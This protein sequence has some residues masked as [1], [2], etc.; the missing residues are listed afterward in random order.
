MH[1]GQPELGVLQS[2]VIVMFRLLLE[3]DTPSE[4]NFGMTFASAAT[5]VTTSSTTG[6]LKSSERKNSVIIALNLLQTVLINDYNHL[7]ILKHVCNVFLT[8][9]P[10]QV[11]LADT[12]IFNLTLFFN[13]FVR[14]I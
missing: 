6:N 4:D 14:T 7:K 8:I 13:L 3:R 9:V 2:G 1:Q 5:D 10:T 11:E 12:N